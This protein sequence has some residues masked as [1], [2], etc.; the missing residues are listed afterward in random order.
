MVRHPLTM[1][2]VDNALQR[3]EGIPQ[4]FPRS[5]FYFVSKFELRI[6]NLEIWRVLRE[7]SRGGD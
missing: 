2:P 4:L 1:S 5:D 3:N 7:I 6:L